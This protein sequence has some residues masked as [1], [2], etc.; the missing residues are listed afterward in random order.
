[1]AHSL[2]DSVEG[3]GSTNVMLKV[4]DIV[5]EGIVAVIVMVY[6][7]GGIS[8]MVALILFSPL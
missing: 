2:V 6:V 8:V 4:C 5:P 7:P 3:H 1:M